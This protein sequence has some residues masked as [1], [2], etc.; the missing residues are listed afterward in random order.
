[1]LFFFFFLLIFAASRLQ[2]DSWRA[3]EFVITE[4]SFVEEEEAEV[5]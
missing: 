2:T 3:Q 4:N 5:M 1:M